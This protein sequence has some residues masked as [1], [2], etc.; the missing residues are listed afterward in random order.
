MI[1]FLQ[2]AF[3]NC[4][5]P[6]KAH[7]ATILIE[8]AT[9]PQAEPRKEVT[10]LS[11]PAERSSRFT[12]GYGRYEGA[13]CYVICE[14]RADGRLVLDDFPVNQTHVSLTLKEGEQA[15]AVIRRATW[16]GTKRITLYVP[17][18]TIQVNATLR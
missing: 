8:S 11:L 1:N 4:I 18:N 16:P 10:V 17:R 15:Y 14:K 12:I 13:E 2:I 6:F 5:A 9:N 7:D 3:H